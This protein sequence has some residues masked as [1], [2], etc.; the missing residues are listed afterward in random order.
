M[1]ITLESSG[2]ST[3]TPVN[4]DYLTI[5]AGMVKLIQIVR[6]C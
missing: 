6:K 3:A 2:S 5:P 1:C 4:E